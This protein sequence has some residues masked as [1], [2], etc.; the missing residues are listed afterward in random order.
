MSHD[1]FIRCC[2]IYFRPLAAASILLFQSGDLVIISRLN[3][4]R[5]HVLPSRHNIKKRNLPSVS[6]NNS[7]AGEIRSFNNQR[8]IRTRVRSYY[9]LPPP[10]R[11]ARAKVLLLQDHLSIHVSLL[12]KSVSWFVVGAFDIH[13]PFYQVYVSCQQRSNQN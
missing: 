6:S 12:V 9:T 11:Q 4:H 5:Q 3:V 1:S 7:V 13:V 10:Y 2:I 8:Y